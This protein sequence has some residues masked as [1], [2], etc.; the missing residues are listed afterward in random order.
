MLEGIQMDY[1][2][3]AFAH[4]H[5][6]FVDAYGAQHPGNQAD[7]RA[8]QS[9]FVHLRALYD[10]FE[11]N[12]SLEDV[13]LRI[14]ALTKKVKDFPVFPALKTA[15]PGWLTVQAFVGVSDAKIYNDLV[16][17]WAKSVLDVYKEQLPAAYWEK[18]KTFS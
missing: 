2:D 6:L 17:S 15:D 3:P 8:R 11:Y 9:G 4:Y 7:R 14:G 16:L 1:Q 12:L 5:R 10:Y 13:R 18:L